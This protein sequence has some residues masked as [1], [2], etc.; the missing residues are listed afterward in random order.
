MLFPS[1]Q[2]KKATVFVYFLTNS[3]SVSVLNFSM[4]EKRYGQNSLLLNKLSIIFQLKPN[5]STNTFYNINFTVF[6]TD[7]FCLPLWGMLRAFILLSHPHDYQAKKKKI[8]R[9]LLQAWTCTILFFFF[10]VCSFP[11]VVLLNAVNTSMDGR[12]S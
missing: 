4:L 7:Q 5:N 12:Q 11:A 6:S 1:W 3:T 8:N 9:R 2:T 10:L